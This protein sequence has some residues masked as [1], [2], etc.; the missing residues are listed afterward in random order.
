MNIIVSGK[1]LDVSDA[2]KSYTESKLSKLDRHFDKEPNAKVVMSV[3]H[4]KH[5]TEAT[6]YVDSLLIRAV[7]ESDDMYQAIDNVLVKLERQITKNKSKLYDKIKHKNLKTS[8]DYEEIPEIL[9]TKK[10]KLVRTKKFNIKP[11]N[12]EEAILQMELL[13]HTFFVF[14]DDQTM[15]TCVVYKRHDGHYGLIEEE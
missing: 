10:S 15:E 13:G 5:I 7:D 14:K 4:G 6:L 2:L 12:V 1:N 11:M 9:E 3:D 8:V